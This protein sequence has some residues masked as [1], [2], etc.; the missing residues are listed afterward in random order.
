MDR[1]VL[2]RRIPR[3]SQLTQYSF[4][5]WIDMAKS[6]PKSPSKKK[7]SPGAKET[8]PLRKQEILPPDGDYTVVHG[9]GGPT[10]AGFHKIQAALTCFKEYQFRE[11]RGITKPA[12]QMPDYFA[13]GIGFQAGRARW[14][15]DK[16][17]AGAR[18][19]KPIED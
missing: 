10:D 15:A 19:W 6:P 7:W 18:G 8:A 13:T 4:T 9:G 11:V 12:G 2:T 14:F 17:P 3:R 5:G 16:F 1:A